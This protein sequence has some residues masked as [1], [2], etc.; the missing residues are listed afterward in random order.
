MAN[1]N[2]G[3]AREYTLQNLQEFTNYTIS[4]AAVNATGA[5]APAVI[6]ITTSAK[7]II[8]RV[9]VVSQ[10]LLTSICQF[11]VVCLSH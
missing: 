10:S 5:S 6:V 2:D 11:P 8:I 7:G 1:V 4:V 3:T 9:S